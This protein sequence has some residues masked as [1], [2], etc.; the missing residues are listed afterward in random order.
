MTSDDGEYPVII[1]QDG[2]KLKTEKMV[3]DRLYH[4]IYDKKVFLFY[5]DDEGLLHC[6]EVEDPAAAKEVTENPAQLENILKKYAEK[7][8]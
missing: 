4:C 3:T 8:E 1:G 7:M 6:Y 2:I 5:K